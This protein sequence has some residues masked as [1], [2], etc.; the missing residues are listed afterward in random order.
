VE[1]D[2]RLVL[3]GHA[4]DRGP[5]ADVRLDQLRARGQGAVEVLAPP[6]REVVEDRHLVAP[7]QQR[8]DQ[9]GADEARAT[10]HQSLH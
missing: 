2:V 5:V 4:L 7:R 3:G 1:D 6:R 8:V 10:C 9:I